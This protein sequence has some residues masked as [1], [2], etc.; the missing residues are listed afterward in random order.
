VDEAARRAIKGQ[1][2]LARVD[3]KMIGLGI[4]H[5]VDRFARMILVRV[6]TEADGDLRERLGQRANA[7]R[8]VV[9]PRQAH[10]AGEDDR[11]GSLGRDFRHQSPQRLQRIE[12]VETVAILRRQPRGQSRRGQANERQPKSR[13][14]LDEPRSQPRPTHRVGRIDPAV[15]GQ[16]RHGG[17]LHRL[18]QRRDAPVEFMVAHHPGV[19]GQRVEKPH[20][21]RTVRRQ[22]LL[23]ALVDVADVD[24]RPVWI[25]AL[26]LPDL[27][28]A[29]RQA[30][31]IAATAVIACRQDVTVQVSGVQDRN[32][33]EFL[34]PGKEC[35]RHTRQQRALPK[36]PQKP[37]PRITR[38][39][40]LH[41]LSVSLINRTVDLRRQLKSPP[42]RAF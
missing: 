11:V 14:F 2:D 13:H 25:Y 30:T 31:K 5:A 16:H 41:G 28:G 33:D 27:R 29:P 42:H 36:Q 7:V 1:V 8:E 37:T 35:G 23:R 10:V 17:T 9:P 26:P 4:E 18:R 38:H 15:A 40:D 24:Q 20:H 22:P 19:V 3:A 39:D 12:H 32:R 21:H 34:L 6:A